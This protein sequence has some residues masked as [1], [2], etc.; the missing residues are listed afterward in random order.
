MANIL[1]IYHSQQFGDTKILAEAVAE[2]ARKSGAAVEVVNTNERRVT[3]QQ[4]LEADAVAVGTPDYFS[5]IAGTI[6]TLF[7]DLYIW[8]K[9]GRPVKGKPAAFFYSC[10]GGGRV[11]HPFETLALKFFRQVGATVESRRPATEE[12]LEKCR[13]LGRELAREAS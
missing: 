11:K 5:Y 10:G 7:D 8:D 2:G 6:K 9:A 1:V 3:L 13:A 4:I 12:A